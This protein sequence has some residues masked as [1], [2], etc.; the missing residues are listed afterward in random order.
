MS[1]VVWQVFGSCTLGIRCYRGGLL[2]TC[3]L[4]IKHL[5]VFDCYYE[6]VFGRLLIV[7]YVGHVLYCVVRCS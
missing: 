2:F 4:M 3:M 5:F 6:T 1:L 7:P